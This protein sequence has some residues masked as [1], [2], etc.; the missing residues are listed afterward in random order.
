VY[1]LYPWLTLDILQQQKLLLG[2]VY[3]IPPS[4][5]LKIEPLSDP[6][7]LICSN[8]RSCLCYG[9]QIPLVHMR[10]HL[11]CRVSH[12]LSYFTGSIPFLIFLADI[13]T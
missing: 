10:R 12:I 13:H 4:K 6:L 1:V 3:H 11:I 5:G 2:R 8:I 7:K 9:I